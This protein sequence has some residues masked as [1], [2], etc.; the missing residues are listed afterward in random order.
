MEDLDA[1]LGCR[2]A[3]AVAAAV[4][5]QGLT[6]V[7]EVVS[8]T[9][10][11]SG[12]QSYLECVGEADGGAACAGLV[13]ATSRGGSMPWVVV[14]QKMGA[15]CREIAGAQ[16]QKRKVCSTSTEA[17]GSEAVRRLAS[18]ADHAVVTE[19]MPES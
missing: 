14:E 1:C 12:S 9:S 5:D 17:S 19:Q 10:A 16:A 8:V 3:V 13:G 15:D 6:A 11:T 4:V 2:L 7:A 18:H